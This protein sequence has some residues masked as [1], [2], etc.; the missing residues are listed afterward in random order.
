MSVAISVCVREGFR[1]LSP[2]PLEGERGLLLQ[3]EHHHC[4]GVPELHLFGQVLSE[5]K[6]HQVKDIFLRQVSLTPDILY[7]NNICSLT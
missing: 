6:S 5:T 2:A 1:L 7:C 4:L 3:D